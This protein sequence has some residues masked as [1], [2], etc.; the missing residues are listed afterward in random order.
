[1][2]YYDTPETDRA[3]ELFSRWSE[4]AGRFW[5][6][7]NRHETERIGDVIHIRNCNGDLARYRVL[8]DGN[9]R[10]QWL[11]TAW[12]NIALANGH[13]SPELLA[14]L[15]SL[16]GTR[17]P[18]CHQATAGTAAGGGLVAGKAN[19]LAAGLVGGR[20]TGLAPLPGP[21]FS[22][23][24][25]ESVHSGQILARIRTRPAVESKVGVS[26]KAEPQR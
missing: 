11:R 19:R 15:V 8:P 18:G 6:Q 25:K 13:A 14:V 21:R 9:L 7:P 2:P 1:M 24:R 17:T 3:V 22:Q 23:T 10:K 12:T 20:R 5:Q 16:I 4:R 26:S